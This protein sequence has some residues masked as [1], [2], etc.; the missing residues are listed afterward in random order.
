MDPVDR[1]RFMRNVGVILVSAP[2]A[3][4]LGRAAQPA[5]LRWRRLRRC[6]DRLS[7]LDTPY[8]SASLAGGRPPY[9]LAESC[10]HAL[11][12]RLILR[13]RY[14]A[15]DLVLS[16]LVT[17]TVAG[18]LHQAYD[19]AVYQLWRS[20]Y[21]PGCYA[22]SVST[23]VA[24]Q[25]AHDLVLQLQALEKMGGA[26]DVPPETLDQIRA[27]IELDLIT[28]SDDDDGMEANFAA[29]ARALAGADVEP[30][31]PG[32]PAALAADLLIQL[33]RGTL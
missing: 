18:A 17:P 21:R 6:W 29:A 9:F 2:L 12:Q 16:G 31:D 30:R 4:L 1:R 10:T 13:H 19:G 32:D 27:A 28:W 26:S 7:E 14:V 8:S 33:Y 11:H 22:I 20:R 3:G 15:D 25:S 23:M 5:S 24:N